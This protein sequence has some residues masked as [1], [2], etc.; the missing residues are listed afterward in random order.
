[1]I[2]TDIS[3]L[4]TRRQIRVDKVLVHENFTDS[5]ND[6]ALLRLG[7]KGLSG[8]RITVILI[9]TYP[10]NN[11]LTEERVDLSVFSPVCLPGIGESFFGQNGT[12][13]GKQRQPMQTLI[14]P[15]LIGLC[16]RLGRHWSPRDLHRQAARDC[17]S[18]R[19]KQLLCGENVPD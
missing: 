18:H 3:L 13:Y 17:S 16:V 7:K 14:N 15:D 10:F 5:G 8:D 2:K 12:V 9:L 6:I 1:M 19:P 11:Q 4:S